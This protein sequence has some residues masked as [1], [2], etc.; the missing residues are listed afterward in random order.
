MLAEKYILLDSLLFKLVPAPEKETTLLGIPEICAK[1]IIM[2]YHSSL[3]ARYQGVIKTYLTIGNKVF[4]LG[5]I[6]HLRLY[7]K[8]VT[9]AYYQ[10]M[11]NP[12]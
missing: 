5:L 11:T 10:E 3:Y 12:I 7:I 9:Y 8:G 6:H 1:K 2:L 4:I